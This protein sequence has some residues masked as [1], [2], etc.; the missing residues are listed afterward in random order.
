MGSIVVGKE[1]DL[2]AFDLSALEFN[3]IFDVASHLIFVV[4]REAVTDVW[5]A[6]ERVV[7]K[8]QFVG[9]GARTAEGKGASDIALWQNRMRSQLGPR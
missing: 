5:V 3:P 8:R 1:A 2:A 4:G 7:Q 9:D 6:G